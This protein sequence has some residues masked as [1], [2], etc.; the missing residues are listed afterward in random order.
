MGKEVKISRQ[1]IKLEKIMEGNVLIF[2]DGRRELVEEISRPN[3]ELFVKVYTRKEHKSSRRI[4]E[5]SIQG[6]I[7]SNNIGYSTK[8]EQRFK[9]QI[10]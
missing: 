1:G 4:Y 3:D 2:S 8:V 5:I 7:Y 10:W 6:K 9:E